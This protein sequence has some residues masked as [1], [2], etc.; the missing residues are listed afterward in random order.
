MRCQVTFGN[1]QIVAADMILRPG[2][3]PSSCSLTAVATDLP[4]TIDTLSFWNDDTLMASFPDATPDLFSLRIV[5][6]HN[7]GFYWHMRVVDRR[8]LWKGIRSLV[9]GS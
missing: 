2:P 6:Q 5:Q 7:Q 1:L 8:W 4:P 9:L 3:E